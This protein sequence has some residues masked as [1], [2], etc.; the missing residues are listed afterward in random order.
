MDKKTYQELK[1]NSKKVAEMLKS[2]DLSV[3]A[4]AELE[5][6]HA[7]ATGALLSVWLPVDWFRRILMFVFILIGL[8][9]AIFYSPW[10]LLFWLLAATFSPRIIGESARFLGRLN[11]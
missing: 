6:T 3:E 2:T 10:F 5:R 7:L 11:K 9:C 8:L 1:D 4:R